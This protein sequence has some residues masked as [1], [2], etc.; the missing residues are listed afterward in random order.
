[1]RLLRIKT[2][3]Y[4]FGMRLTARSP[5]LAAAACF[6]AFVAVLAAAGRI[7]LSRADELLAFARLQTV[8]T[9]TAL[10]VMAVSAGLVAS[11]AMI[12]DP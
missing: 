3:R 9:V 7:V 5:L 8:A 10:A 12:S 4:R 6:L 1:M 11:A 2:S